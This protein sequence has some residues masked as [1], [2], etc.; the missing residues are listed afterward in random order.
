MQQTA[1]DAAR[2]QEL[3][4]AFVEEASSLYGVAL[5]SDKAEIA[6]LVGLYAMV[7]RMRI[8]SS[9]SVT[10]AADKVVRLIVDTYFA[11]NKTLRELRDVMK[12]SHIDPLRAFSEACREDLRAVRPR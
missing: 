12:S 5:A 9:P 8:L 11:P 4:K 6:T 3:Y 10:D 2:R 1:A 7:A